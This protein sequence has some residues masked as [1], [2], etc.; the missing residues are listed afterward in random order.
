MVRTATA[1]YLG[2]SL[3]PES[4]TLSTVL[5]LFERRLRL[6]ALAERRAGFT[7][8]NPYACRFPGTCRALVD[9]STP[10]MEQAQAEGALFAGSVE[11]GDFIRLRE[12]SLAVD[13]PTAAVRALRLRSVV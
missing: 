11:R 7:Q 8:L 12:V 3:P 13:L 2:Q 1:V 6:S 10:L 4:Q 5:G 9:R